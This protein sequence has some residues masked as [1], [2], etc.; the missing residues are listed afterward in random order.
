MTFSCGCHEDGRERCGT[1]ATWVCHLIP[2]VS[3]YSGWCPPCY[4]ERLRSVSLSSKATPT[5]RAK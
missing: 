1:H 5:R 4:L 3:N 2:T